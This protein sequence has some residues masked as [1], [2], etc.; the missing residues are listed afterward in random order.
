VNRYSAFFGTVL[1]GMVATAAPAR[2]DAQIFTPTFQSPRLGSDVGVYLSDEPGGFA[3]E[4]IWRRTFGTYDLGFRAGIADI[5]DDTGILLGAEYRNPL[6]LETQPVEMAVTGGLQVIVG[7]RSAVG[8]QAGLS[9]GAALPADN[10]V[11]VP[12][13]H[14]RIALH[15]ARRRDGLEVDVLADVGFDVHFAGSLAL[16]FAV[17]LSRPTSDWG[18]GFAWR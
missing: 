16:R 5:G 3:L 17:G 6:A 7:D 18:I 11:F 13:I 12:Y 1:L 4:G 8:F 10:L 2:L 9:I 15:D 14:P